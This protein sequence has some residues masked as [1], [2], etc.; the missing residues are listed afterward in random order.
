[1]DPKFSIT[2]LSNGILDTKVS[3]ILR[4]LAKLSKNL[5]LF[6]PTKKGIQT[7]NDSNKAIQ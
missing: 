4:Y 3:L 7:S 1:M 6:L 5:N 2:Q